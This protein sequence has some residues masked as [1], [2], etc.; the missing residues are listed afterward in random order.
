ML[1]DLPFVTHLNILNLLGE[2]DI[3][4]GQ[5]GLVRCDINNGAVEFLNPNIQLC[6]GNFQLFDM[7]NGD[8]TFL[9]Q[10]LDL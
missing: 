10:A 3:L 8:Q 2:F 4:L 6:D 1:P 5:T 9:V 7:F